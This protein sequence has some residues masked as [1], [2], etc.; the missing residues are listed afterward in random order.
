MQFL[1]KRFILRL[2]VELKGI[3]LFDEI[4]IVPGVR[5]TDIVFRKCALGL[6]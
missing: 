4:M 2:L 3:Y 1:F 5:Y 6:F